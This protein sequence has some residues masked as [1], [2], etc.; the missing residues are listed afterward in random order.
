MTPRGLW[1]SWAWFPRD[2]RHGIKALASSRSSR[3]LTSCLST[4]AWAAA[5]GRHSSICRC[6]HQQLAQQAASRRHVLYSSTCRCR[7]PPQSYQPAQPQQQHRYRA[8][9]GHVHDPRG[10]VA[11]VGQ[12]PPS[13]GL[14]QAYGHQP[15]QPQH[16][17]Y[18][19]AHYAHHAHQ[20]QQAVTAVSTVLAPAEGWAYRGSWQQQ[21]Q[22]QPAWLQLWWGAIGLVGTC[23][24]VI[25][26]PLLHMCSTQPVGL[27]VDVR[28]S[29]DVMLRMSALQAV[30]GL[31]CWRSTRGQLPLMAWH[32]DVQQSPTEVCADAV[33]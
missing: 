28:M 9:H 4:C 25:T 31:C 10:Y 29:A 33:S 32:H 26:S 12:G 20:Q 21:Q 1:A 14:G 23:L 15:M 22:R 30:K 27:R 18:Q 19:N 8:V 2:H 24:V 13:R 17:Q 11:G 7:H 5:S 3:P 6:R 16:G